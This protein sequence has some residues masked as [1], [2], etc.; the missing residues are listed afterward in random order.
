LI[1]AIFGHLLLPA[2]LIAAGGTL[3]MRRSL[4]RKVV[5]N[6]LIGSAALFVLIGASSV[7]DVGDAF[8]F[9]HFRRTV[10]VEVPAL[11]GRTLVIVGGTGQ[12]E[13]I[14]GEELRVN[15]TISG[16]GDRNQLPTVRASTSD[17][18]VTVGL[19]QDSS[20]RQRFNFRSVAYSV[21]VPEGTDLQIR[22]TTGNID[23]EVA[24][25]D[26][27]LE[28]TTGNIDLQILDG[29]ASDATF[30][31][32]STTGNIEVDTDKRID[33]D[34]ASSTGRVEVNG[35]KVSEPFSRTIDG[36]DLQVVTTTGNIDIQDGA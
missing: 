17:K 7:D 4:P 12:V 28:S 33:L 26:V 20:T 27:L 8:H 15:A 11:E 13:V 10:P 3:L 23:A 19:F 35:E 31:L 9:S 5:R 18:N 34:L 29:T 30:G 25:G 1:P 24:G 21:T 22:T 36:L 16:L 14:E 6:A 32:Q 2:L